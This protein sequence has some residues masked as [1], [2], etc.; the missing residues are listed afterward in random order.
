MAKGSN[1]ASCLVIT[2]DAE[3]NQFYDMIFKRYVKKPTF[4]ELNGHLHFREKNY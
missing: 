1:G 4:E 2:L 3:G